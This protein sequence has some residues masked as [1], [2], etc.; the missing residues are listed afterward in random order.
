MEYAGSYALF[1]YRL[2]DPAGGL[3]Y[4]NLRLIRTFEYGLDP[5]SSE[6]G[7]VLVHIDMVRNS[8]PLMA[9]TMRCLD[10]ASRV[11]TAL[12]TVAE[13]TALN[14]GLTDILG[15]MKRINGVME[16]MWAKSRPT[17]YTSF[18]TFIFGI[19]SQSMFPDGFVYEGLNDDKPLSFRGESG[20]NDPMVPLMDN[21]LQVPMPDT[22]L[23]EILRDFRTYRPSN[24]KAF[25]RYVR[26]RSA[27]LD[28]RN[29][30]LALGRRVL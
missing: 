29:F 13:R 20:A 16:T 10:V 11:R 27:E 8:G 18:R 23:T 22:P 26:D 19:T 7:F 5:E 15:A 17:E 1:N 2:E 9:G 25:L 30:A 28:L 6:A 21:L 12:G 4:S 3:A 24:H 14:E